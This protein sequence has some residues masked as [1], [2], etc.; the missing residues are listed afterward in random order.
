MLR[1]GNEKRNYS[2]RERNK[3]NTLVSPRGLRKRYAQEKR[4]TLSNV[5]NI[6]PIQPPH[7]FHPKYY[8]SQQQHR[9]HHQNVPYNHMISLP[10]RDVVISMIPQKKTPI[11]ICHPSL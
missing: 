6:L 8:P 7:P 10:P 3:G 2:A 4:K 5:Q 9:S 1:T 11:F